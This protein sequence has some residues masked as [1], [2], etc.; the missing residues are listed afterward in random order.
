M[1]QT[2]CYFGDGK[3]PLYCNILVFHWSSVMAELITLLMF[4]DVMQDQ[5]YDGVLRSDTF[6]I[7]G[8]IVE[9]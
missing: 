9:I 6:V 3:Q 1:F 5:Q 8:I 2:F 4:D 7:S